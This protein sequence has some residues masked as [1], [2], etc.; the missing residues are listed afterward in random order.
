MMDTSLYFIHP[1]MGAISCAMRKTVLKTG[2]I[3]W[4]VF[5]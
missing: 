2:A 4:D 3:S 5:F 1:S